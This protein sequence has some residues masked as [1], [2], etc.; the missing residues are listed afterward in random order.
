MWKNTGVKILIIIVVF[1]ILIVSS[2]MIF[3]KNPKEQA[4]SVVTTVVRERLK[5][6]N[7]AKFPHYKKE[8]VCISDDDCMFATYVDSKN[9]FGAI[10]RDR[11]MGIVRMNDNKWDVESLSFVEAGVGS[12]LMD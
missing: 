12:G 5:N 2:L 10:V 4:W 3:H 8:L 7:S 9:A 1:A 6:P 11:F